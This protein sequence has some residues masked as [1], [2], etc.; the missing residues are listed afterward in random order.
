MMARSTTRSKQRP[1]TLM[2]DRISQVDKASCTARPDH[3]FGSFASLP[4]AARLRRMSAMPSIATEWWCCRLI[5]LNAGRL[6]EWPPFLDFRVLKQAQRLRCLLTPRKNLLPE[7]GE[8]PARRWIIQ[9]IHHRGRYFCGDVL[10]RVLGDP[11]TMPV[12]NMKASQACF[13]CRWNIRRLRKAVL[14]GD[15]ICFDFAT[16]YLRQ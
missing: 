5:G 1:D 13:V 4:Q 9:R 6:D 10:R 7:I 14:G 16:A 8:P 3:T 2:Q 11:K 15:R 12:Q